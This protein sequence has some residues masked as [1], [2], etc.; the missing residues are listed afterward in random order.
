[1]TTSSIPSPRRINYAMQA[2]AARVQKEAGDDIAKQNRRAWQLALT[3]EP[4][5]DEMGDAM[6]VVQKLGLAVLCRALFNSNE[7]LFL[8]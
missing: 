8:P 1:M 7:F 6:P 3:R 4:T 2:F 5:A